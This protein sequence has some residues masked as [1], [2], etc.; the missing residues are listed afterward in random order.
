MKFKEFCKSENT[1][2]NIRNALL[3]CKKHSI[4]SLEFDKGT[5]TLNPEM[6][7]EG[8]Y[9][10]S[11]HGEIGFK[12]IGFLLKDMKD[13]TIDGGGSEF[14]FEG[15]MNPIVVDG[16]ENITIKN[17]S[18]KTL[19]PYSA[20]GVVSEVGSG[21]FVLDLYGNHPYFIAGSKFYF[22][23][24]RGDDYS[25]MANSFSERYTDK[26]RLRED[27]RNVALC[28][29]YNPVTAKE[30]EHNKILFEHVDVNVKLGNTIIIWSER[31]YAPAIFLKDSKNTFI[32][33]YTVYTA[34]GMGVLGQKCEN[35]TIDNMTNTYKE[36]GFLSLNADSTHF[37]HCSGLIHIKNSHFKAQ[38]DDSL[39][40]HGIYTK[41]IGK[42]EDHLIVK[43]M[44][45][46]QLGTDIYDEGTQIEVS[47]NKSLIDYEKF[48]VTGVEKINNECTILY[49]DK[50]TDK[51]TL[52]DVVEDV[53]LFPDVIFENNDSSYSVGRGMLLA[54]RGKIIVRN[55]YFSNSG[56]AIKLESNGSYWYESG[57][58]RDILIEGNTFDECCYTI[59]GDAVVHV[60][61]REAAQEGKY[62]HSNMRIIGNKFINC[63]KCS[64][65]DVHDIDG[66]TFKDNII[67]SDCEKESIAE[68]CINTHIE[69]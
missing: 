21:S 22:G 27:T 15:V 18:I 64:L 1:A 62:Y 25:S 6:A 23:Y 30:I 56:S 55:N 11:N 54:S 45:D 17:L 20:S 5:Y 16:C 41:I 7:M 40:I 39:N 36:K 60:A 3:Y 37:V 50:S 33:N 42:G 2:F 10:T 44:H 38:M 43:Y 59:W 47:N 46:Q 31:R 57:A 9:C 29:K 48:N 63:N 65:F 13:F 28:H 69:F 68:H 67:Q 8:V 66:F 19:H 53:R 12:R 51:V 35:I 4:K 49:V 32:E 58:T 24:S 52:G 14:L 34:I 26:E 61:P